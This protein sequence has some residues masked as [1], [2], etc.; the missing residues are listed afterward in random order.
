MTRRFSALLVFS[1]ATVVVLAVGCQQAAAPP[2][3]ALGRV[4]DFSF[5]DQDGA[6]VTRRSLDGEPWVASFFFTRCQTVCPIITGRVKQLEAL[7]SDRSTP[8][9]IV[10]F[11]VDPRHDQS[12]VLKQFAD[13][14]EVEWSLVTGSESAIKAVARSFSVALEGE[15]DPGQPDFG[16]LHSG[17]LIL[18]DG[19]ANIRTYYRSSEDGVEDRILADARRLQTQP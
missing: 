19:N 3:P 12:T 15:A 13:A 10:S 7:A 2:A 1:V 18:V 11:T 9:R 17:H 5:V 14:N 6:V 8:L 16:I 4:A